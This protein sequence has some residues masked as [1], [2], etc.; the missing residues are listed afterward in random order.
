MLVYEVCRLPGAGAI[1]LVV[2]LYE[3]VLA[4]LEQIQNAERDHG[5]DVNVV[6]LIAI[7]LHLKS[8][9]MI[10]E[11]SVSL[12]P[13]LGVETLQLSFPQAL[14]RREINPDG[15]NVGSRLKFDQTV[16]LV[17]VD[18]LL[19]VGLVREIFAVDITDDINLS[20]LLA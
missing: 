12:Q 1:V 15:M 7:V 16:A 19:E 17:K 3:V 14:N 4:S 11:I 6:E 8:L 13:I 5:L 20:R 10:V 2:P 18:I 9:L